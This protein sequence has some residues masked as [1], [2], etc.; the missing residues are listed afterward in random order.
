MAI[1]GPN[2]LTPV[3]VISTSGVVGELLASVKTVEK[4]STRV[5]ENRAVSVPVSPGA[6]SI[7]KVSANE[8]VASSKS[9][10]INVNVSVP[11]FSTRI[12][13][14]EMAS[15]KVSEKSKFS[16]GTTIA[17]AFSTVKLT[18]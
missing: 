17:G 3:R 2:T 11:G 1:S 16:V 9:A 13:F 10:E 8:K 15:T 12:S 14:D 18:E 5:G 4:L 6:T 7:G